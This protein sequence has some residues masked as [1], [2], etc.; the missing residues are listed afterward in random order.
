MVNP[1]MPN[2]SRNTTKVDDPG[3][4]SLHC[5]VAK[6][7]AP[8]TKNI[9]LH[10]PIAMFRKGAVDDLFPGLLFAMGMQFVVWIG[11]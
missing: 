6:G 10:A 7:A 9:V 2:K 8:L 1:V 11:T 5:L 3:R 4:D